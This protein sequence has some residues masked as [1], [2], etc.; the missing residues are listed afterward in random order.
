MHFYIPEQVNVFILVWS[1][2]CIM[3]NN[4]FDEEYFKFGPIVK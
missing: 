2:L 4:M 1:I 3:L